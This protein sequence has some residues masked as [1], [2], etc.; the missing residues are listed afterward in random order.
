M[1][2][3]RIACEEVR[4]ELANYMEDD[5]SAE[6]RLRIEHHF[7]ECD[8]CYAIYDGLQKIVRLIGSSDVI[9]LPRG[10]SHRLY[11]RIRGAH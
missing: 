3:L 11:Q 10:F 5:V 1:G 9:E 2:N 6:L 8:G 4:K 7:F